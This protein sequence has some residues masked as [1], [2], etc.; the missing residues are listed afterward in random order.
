MGKRRGMPDL[1]PD[2]ACPVE[3]ALFRTDVAA[4]GERVYG[5]ATQR[6][7][8][9]SRRL[10]PVHL[11]KAPRRRRLCTTFLLAMTLASSGCDTVSSLKNSVIGPGSAPQQGQPGFIQGF[12]GGVA[13][14]EPRATLA[15]RQ[16]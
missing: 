15:A 11:G 14:D 3:L 2:G 10:T 13:T 6:T 16:V 4:V 9:A 5:T 7:I 12:L 1:L 8:R